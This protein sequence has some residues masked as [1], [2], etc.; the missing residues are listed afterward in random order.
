MKIKPNTIVAT[1]GLG[2][3]LLLSTAYPSDTYDSAIPSLTQTSDREVRPD[4]T[5]ESTIVSSGL[6]LAIPQQESRKVERSI[7]LVEPQDTLRGLKGVMILIEDI[8]TDVENYGLTKSLLKREVESRLREADIPVL[9]R[10][11]AFKTPG[12]PYLYL[13]LTTHNTGIELY[14]F[15]VQIQFNQDVCMIREPSIRASGTTWI[16]N[17]VG[18]VGARNLPA[19]TEDVND[20]TDKFIHDYLAANRQ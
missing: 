15:A 10:E 14:S 11:E 13:T 2:T 12:K 1:C 17:V 3:L 20:L 6:K 4:N 18:I 5:E 19:I 8:D 9:T 7:S 16:A